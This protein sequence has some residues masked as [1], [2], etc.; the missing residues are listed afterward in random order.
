F[1]IIVIN[2]G[3]GG[4]FR[5]LP[6]NKNS[7]NFDKF[8]E[9]THEFNAKLLCEMYHFQYESAS[10]GAELNEALKSFYSEGKSPKLL[11]IFT[12]RKLND[13]ILLEY[14]KYMRD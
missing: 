1:R 14:F 6:G 3:G 13:R 2:N 12:P 8:F 10:S 7:E 11:E 5:I 9:T 4:I